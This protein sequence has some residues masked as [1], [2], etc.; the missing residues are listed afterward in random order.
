MCLPTFYCYICSSISVIL[1]LNHTKN[2][3]TLKILR[4]FCGAAIKARRALIILAWFLQKKKT[5]KKMYLLHIM[6]TATDEF[7]SPTMIMQSCTSMFSTVSLTVCVN[8]M[9]CQFHVF[10]ARVV[11]YTFKWL[12]LFST[13][14]KIW[15]YLCYFNRIVWQTDWL[16]WLDWLASC[17]TGWLTACLPDWLT[18]LGWLTNAGLTI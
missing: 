13:I 1:W 8:Q 6:S 14:C 9:H 7:Y 12:H 15:L 4:L 18:E 10:L 11:H 17:L 5:D 3:H 2:K 16:I